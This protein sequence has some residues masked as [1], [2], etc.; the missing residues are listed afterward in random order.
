MSFTP[1]PDDVYLP[2]IDRPGEVASLITSHPSARLFAL[3]A[4]TFPPEARV[5]ASANPSAGTPSV[6]SDPKDWTY[7]ELENWL[8]KVPREEVNDATWVRKARQCILPGSELI[9]E[10]I[11]GALGIPPELDTD[12]EPQ[13][14]PLEAYLPPP[15]PIP[16]RQTI[17]TGITSNMLDADVF[18]PDSPVVSSSAQYTVDTH[19]SPS[20]SELELNELSIEPVLA[21]PPPPPSA[22]D[23]TTGANMTS[24]QEVREEDEEEA[25]QDGTESVGSSTG[26]SG[27]E[28]VH[29]LRF[30][31]SVSMSS[32]VLGPGSF[33][34][35]SLGAGS[36]GAG[37]G[38]SPSPMRLSESEGAYDALNERGPGHPLFPSSFA[39]LSMKPT[40]RSS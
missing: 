34:G 30:S 4:Q 20:T 9:W 21:I 10:R 17:V 2:F 18:E 13:P 7:A 12:E 32:P 33:G 23:P 15:I 26:T 37:R 36:F 24:L 25:P 14:D 38:A 19:G 3:L 22:V 6:D 35:S 39:H 28:P 27:A 31:T 8:K 40:L 16:G 29:G 1:L 5:P 11:K